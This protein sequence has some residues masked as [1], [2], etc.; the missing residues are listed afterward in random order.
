MSH[1]QGPIINI[2]PK[3][4]EEGVIINVTACHYVIM[5]L[6]SHAKEPRH[7]LSS[8]STTKIILSQEKSPF[9]KISDVSN[10]NH[11]VKSILFWVDLLLP[12]CI[13]HIFAPARKPVSQFFHTPDH[14]PEYM[15]DHMPDYT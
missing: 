14:S 15:P 7:S 8:C 4:A 6:I 3:R 13:L 10:G 11:K 2:A 12:H 1:S 5:T 9:S